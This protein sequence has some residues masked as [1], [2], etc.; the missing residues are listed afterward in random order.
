MAKK[1]HA[2]YRARNTNNYMQRL[3]AELFAHIRKMIPIIKMICSKDSLDGTLLSK[4][5]P[6]KSLE[7][8]Y[9]S[10]VFDSADRDYRN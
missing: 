3:R 1:L 7:G 5:L 2:P 10:K 4:K 9:L 8:V 6:L